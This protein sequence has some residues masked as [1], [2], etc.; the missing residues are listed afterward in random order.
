MHICLH[1]ED[2]SL[3]G[4]ISAALVSDIHMGLNYSDLY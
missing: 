3:S 4:T 2:E 1:A